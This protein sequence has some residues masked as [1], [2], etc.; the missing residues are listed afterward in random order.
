MRYCPDCGDSHECTAQAASAEADA[1]VRIAEIE[2]RRDV[3]VAELRAQETRTEAEA[4]TEI[5]GSEAIVEAAAAEGVAEGLETVIDAASP[6]APAETGAEPVVI[7]EQPAGDGGD[8]AE[9]PPPVA[10]ETREPVASR[11]SNPWWG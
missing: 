9:E 11:K 2:A 3:R 5:A 8:L 1:R 6:D 4:A 10:E 7:V